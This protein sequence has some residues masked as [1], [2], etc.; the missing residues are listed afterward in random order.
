MVIKKIICEFN[1]YIGIDWRPE[2]TVYSSLHNFCE[3]YREKGIKIIKLNQKERYISFIEAVNQKLDLNSETYQEILDTAAKYKISFHYHQKLKI[4]YFLNSNDKKTYIELLKCNNHLNKE[5]QGVFNTISVEDTLKELQNMLIKD[6]KY[7]EVLNSIFSRYCFN[8][9]EK[10]LYYEFFSGQLNDYHH[11]N[12]Y[13]S[14]LGR[15]YPDMVNRDSAM[16]YFDIDNTMFIEGY[17]VGVNNILETIQS[18]Y[19]TLNN[20]CNLIVKLP[21]I[22]IGGKSIQ[23][24]LYSDIILYAEKHI[25]KH[26]DRPYF[27][28]KTIEKI[29]SDYINDLNNTA[30]NFELASSGFI[31]KDCFVIKKKENDRYVLLL[32][33]EKNE[34]DEEKFHVQHAGVRKSNLI[35][36]QYWM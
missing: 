23:W 12:D 7:D 20:H 13:R 19:K 16:V 36:I 5:L 8:C 28:W 26:I 6:N 3:Y 11:D 29:T 32:V 24:D 35:H 34:R 22:K 18:V 33:F 10:E 14:F 21:D 1:S 30:T 31:F 17:N 4:K 25:L 15:I 27:K 2:K 9:V